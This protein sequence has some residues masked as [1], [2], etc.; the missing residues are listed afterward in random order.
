[1]SEWCQSRD[2]FIIPSFR[3]SASAKD[4]SL[5]LRKILFR[6]KGHLPRQAETN[7]VHLFIWR[8]GTHE[9][10]ARFLGQRVPNLFF[11]TLSSIELE[12]GGRDRTLP[13]LA[14]LP[15]VQ[16]CLFWL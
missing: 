2:Y 3:T 4:H 6:L 14:H 11:D 16:F 9:M 5:S 15:N 8:D 13:R 7:T 1:M 12:I 10:Q